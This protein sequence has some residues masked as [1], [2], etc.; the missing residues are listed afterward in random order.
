MHPLLIEEENMYIDTSIG[1]CGDWRKKGRQY[2]ISFGAL[3][4]ERIN[5]ILC[6]GRCAAAVGD[7]WEVSRVIPVCALTG[8]AVG[9]AAALMVK[10]NV[11]CQQLDIKFLQQKLTEDGVLIHL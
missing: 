4:D 2:E 3:H 10:D 8:Q 1:C 5:N 7:A 6:A 11:A 9:T